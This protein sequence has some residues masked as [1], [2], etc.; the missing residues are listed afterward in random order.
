[1]GGGS[2]PHAHYRYVRDGD[3]GVELMA[4]RTTWQLCRMGLLMLLEGTS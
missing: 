4:V 3:D 2:E 1:M